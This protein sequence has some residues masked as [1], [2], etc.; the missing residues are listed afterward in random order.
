MFLKGQHALSV[1][2]AYDHTDFLD[3][4]SR[5]GPLYPIPA[6]N[7][8]GQSLTALFPSIPAGATGSL[9]NAQFQIAAANST[10]ALTTTDKTC[11][12]C[13][14]NA[15]GQKVYASVTRGTYVG[16]NVQ[17]AGRYHA[18]YGNDVY[19]MNRYITLN[20]GVRWEE[21]RTAGDLLSYAFTGSWSPRV[22]INIDPKGD[23]RSKLFFNFGRNYWAM[24][25]DAAIRQL[26]NE[27]DDTSYFFA[28][29]INSDGSYTIIP[30][31][32]HNLNGLPKSTDATGTRASF[33]KPSFASSTGEGILP[34]TR[35][36]Y[37]DEYVI[38]VE[39]QL[40]SSIV[41][42]GRYT[43]RRLGRVIEDIGSQSPE[44]STIIGNFVGGITNP[45]PQTDVAVNENELT[46]T[47]AQFLAKNPGVTTAAN[48]QAPVAGCTAKNDTFFAVGGP[49][50]D[51]RNNPVGGACFLNIATADAGPGDGI[52]DGL[53]NPV[54]RYQAV[55]LEIDK[56]FSNHWLAQI[57][58]RWGTLFGNYEGAYRNDNG[59]S[60]PG[61]SS[62]FD[63]TAGKLGLLASQFQNGDL[64][65]DRTN[66]GNLFLSYN[67]SSDT[68]FVHAAKGLTLGMGLR[69]QSGV[70]LSILGDHPI[71]LNQGE[72]PIGGRG[73]AGR[74]PSTMQLDIH[75]EY[76]KNFGDKFV[77][78][79]AMDMFNMTNSQF[80]TGRVQ[81]TQTA[82]AGVGVPPP[83]N[84]DYNRPTSFQTP[85]YA[86]GSIR[87]QF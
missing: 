39:R 38:G 87:F 70:P 45:S 73:A 4:P 35:A 19:K 28:P 76:P 55:E 15:T 27:Q 59:Q 64:S 24:P 18:A 29:V 78:K 40:T 44:G 17:A 60:D 42:K 53:V 14:T 34:G 41:F 47:Q 20:G 21:Q 16:L 80:Q 36:S 22:G 6:Q 83:L 12:Q 9:T 56:R 7:A 30:D 26:G 11:T 32:A 3:Q 85:F 82:A 65:T 54:R 49:F 71:Y 1:G 13:P 10:P 31:S 84:A 37:E 63:F 25:L 61:I 46:Y 62:L 50:I 79:L 67:I 86:R 69:G 74:T 75:T 77:V 58:Y 52:P 8:L 2:Y 57:N 68:R 72:V 23:G 48:Y 81:Y 66:V 33:G 51:G 43:D 5:S